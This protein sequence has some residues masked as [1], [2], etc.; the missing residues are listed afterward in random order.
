MTQTEIF[1]VNKVRS[2]CCVQEL[3]AVNEVLRKETMSN[4]IW[5]MLEIVENETISVQF[6]RC[7]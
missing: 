6:V 2:A 3:Q 4:V 5:L 7:G 1:L